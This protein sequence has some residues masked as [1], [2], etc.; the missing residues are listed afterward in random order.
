MKIITVLS[1]YGYSVNS[2][3]VKKQRKRKRKM[4]NISKEI[5]L[6][7]LFSLLL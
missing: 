5:L 2:K 3:R 4:T 1:D 7:L 6:D